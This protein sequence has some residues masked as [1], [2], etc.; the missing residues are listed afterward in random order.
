M[1]KEHIR[2]CL[3]F[4]GDALAA[5][6]RSKDRSTQ[7]GAIVLDSDYNLR[8]SGYNGFPR[9]VNDN[10]ESRHERPIKYKYTAHAEENC[11][12]NAARVGV[13]LKGCT[14]VVTSLHPCSTC[15]RLIINSG[16]RY[17]LAPLE[18]ANARW[19]EEGELAAE[20]FSEAGVEV[21]FY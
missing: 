13:S 19:N 16:I 17:V 7:V 15:A 4:L 2:K 12:A 3:K 10:V 21:A 5:K 8:T 18:S 1:E 11:V 6:G 20:M 14:L 9:Q